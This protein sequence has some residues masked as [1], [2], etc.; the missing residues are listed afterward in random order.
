M[1]PNQVH[2]HGLPFSPASPPIPDVPLLVVPQASAKSIVLVDDEKS[3]TD[4]L[5]QMLADNLD[6]P[7]HAFTRPLDALHALPSIDPAVIVTDFHM[8]QL[9]GFEFIRRANK[10]VPQAHFV[11]I[12]GHNLS[13]SEEEM[14][15]LSGLKGFLRKP[16]GWRKLADE[17][18]RVW[19]Q[20]C[21]APSHRAD[22][23]SL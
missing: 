1:R 9:S 8:P 11:L 13:E 2:A 3:Y 19:P 16:F 20:S 22:A 10:V 6:C 18:I 23:T 14:A 4:L 5:T 21:M 15:R 12:T 17:I 7:V